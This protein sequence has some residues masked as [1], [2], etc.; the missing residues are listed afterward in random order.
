VA[1]WQSLLPLYAENRLKPVKRIH[2]HNSIEMKW[3]FLERLLTVWL[4]IG[5]CTAA[6]AQHVM[7]M[8]TSAP[9]SPSND[10]HLTTPIANLG[11]GGIDAESALPAARIAFDN[12]VKL[13]NSFSQEEALRAFMLAEHLDPHC[14]MCYWGEASSLAPTINYTVPR[15]AA[16][17]AV[18]A[19]SH[20][21]SIT[22]GLSPKAKGIIAGERQR[23]LLR[24]G[25]WVVDDEAE[26]RATDALAERFPNDD[27]LQVSA[28]NAQMIAA[29]NGMPGSAS[30][31]DPHLA[32]A[33]VRLETVLRRNSTYTPAIHLYLH[34]TEWQGRS[35][36]SLPYAQRLAALAPKSG[37]LLHMASHIDYHT[38]NYEAAAQ[39]NM[40]AVAADI[41]YVEKMQPPGGMNALP[42]HQHNLLFGLVAS[43]ISGD[44]DLALKFANEMQR[45]SPPESLAFAESYFAFGRF[46]PTPDVLNLKAPTASLASAFYHFAR[47]EA[48]IRDNDSH[49][50]LQ[51][52]EIIENIK[53]TGSFEHTDPKVVS[54][55]T[56]ALHMLSGRA[57]MV[58]KDY[59][60]AVKEYSFASSFE[61][62]HDGYRDPQIWPWPPRRSLAEALLLQ[63]NPLGARKE[64]ETTL[65]AV[66]DDPIS[67]TVLGAI[68]EKMRDHPSSSTPEHAGK[69][70][71]GPTDSLKPAM[72]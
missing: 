14:A 3:M 57:A 67:G 61:A 42:M 19:L 50:A 39:A 26:A 37:H 23:Y 15:Q 58:R 40:A 38:G 66:P 48:L 22:D 68:E 11:D 65:Q 29:E 51:E 2:I 60:T 28:A 21:E 20:A 54:M 25:N 72:I 47:G 70:W 45:S 69:V 18:E 71:L 56:V 5:L 24:D 27:A 33:Q 62:E 16:V 7:Q 9:A 34:L 35:A 8:T 49:G 46:A 44:K 53:K 36:A 63:G 4:V 1:I 32:R 43:L 13:N 59:A 31:T 64:I 41:E 12:G 55:L 52:A 10:P 30:A 6:K 17:R